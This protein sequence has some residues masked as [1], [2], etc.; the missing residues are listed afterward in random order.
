MTLKHS[1]SSHYYVT[2]KKT[3]K[4]IEESKIISIIFNSIV[5][6][7]HQMHSD[8]GFNWNDNS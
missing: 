5:L 1:E 8:T 6:F 2:R 4:I 3:K 7:P